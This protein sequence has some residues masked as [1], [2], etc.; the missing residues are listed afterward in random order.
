MTSCSGFVRSMLLGS[1]ACFLGS[2]LVACA[3]PRAGMTTTTA[4][5]VAQE[6]THEAQDVLPTSA[7]E[8]P[9]AAVTAA[10]APATGD[11]VC[12]SKD[13]F[14]VSSELYITWS[15][16]E[17]KGV[18]KQIAPSGMETETRIRAEREGNLLFADDVKSEPDLLVHTATVGKRDGKSFI[19]LGDMKAPWTACE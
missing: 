17:G 2:A 1:F 14:G 6:E 18:L 15:G 13:A 4:S 7:R 8:A 10:E 9:A 12:R 5:P 3:G 11:L 16:K 19:R